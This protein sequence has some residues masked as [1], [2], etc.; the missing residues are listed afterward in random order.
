MTTSPDFISVQGGC[1]AHVHVFEPAN[2][3]Y[4]ANRAYT[5]GE[6]RCSDL[7]AHMRQLGVSR[8]VIVQPSVYG[9]DNSCL[10]AA[11]KHLGRER[12]RGVAVVDYQ[13]ISVVDLIELRD[14]GVR[15]LRV[16]FEAARSQAPVHRVSVIRAT[17]RRAKEACLAV[18]LYVDT[19][20]AVEAAE[21]LA[22][23]GVPLIL[24]HFAGFK[25]GMDL[26]GETFTRLLRV[27]E[28]GNIWVKLSAPYRTGSLLPD[29][30]DLRPAV[31]SLITTAPERMVWASDWPHTGG[32]PRHGNDPASIEPFR[33]IDSRSDL[34]RLR[35]W[36]TDDVLYAKIVA[37]NAA[38]IF[39]FPD[40]S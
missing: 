3:P 29:Y 28:T 26:A 25:C 38:Q 23:E 2:Y 35:C 33:Q 36:V 32:G 34:A 13:S 5:P 39:D 11:L 14:A 22:K 10:I 30:E 24:D 18:Q 7:E 37:Q 4:A 17:A 12:T 31:Q 40:A 6:A 9:V 8:C 20:T 19:Q 21:D 1:D 15:A 27:L 16:N